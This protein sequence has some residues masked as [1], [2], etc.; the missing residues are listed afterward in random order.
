MLHRKFFRWYSRRWRAESA[1]MLPL[2]KPNIQT[3]ISPIFFFCS[4]QTLNW[5]TSISL[6]NSRMHQ[7]CFKVCELMFQWKTT[8]LRHQILHQ[9]FALV[10]DEWL[11]PV[12]FCIGEGGIRCSFGMVHPI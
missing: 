9:S 2:L 4:I 5:E 1:E 7:P 12:T 11:S 10:Q 6:N 3:R 8:T